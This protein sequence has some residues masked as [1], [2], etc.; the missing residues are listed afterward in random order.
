MMIVNRKDLSV[1]IMELVN[2]EQSA[3]PMMTVRMV[4]HVKRMEHAP[5]QMIV[6]P[7]KIALLDLSVK[8]E[9]VIVILNAAQMLIA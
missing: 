3:A 1:M 6:V 9:A 2:V 7:M 4:R 8:M 5:V